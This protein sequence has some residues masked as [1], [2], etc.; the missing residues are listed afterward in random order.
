M[1]VTTVFNSSNCERVGSASMSK[2]NFKT[3][4]VVQNSSH[5]HTTDCRS[6]LHWHSDEPN[7]CRSSLINTSFFPYQNQVT[8]A[9]NICYAFHPDQA[10]PKDVQIQ[11]ILNPH[12][13]EKEKLELN[14]GRFITEIQLTFQM[15]INSGASKFQLLIC[16]PI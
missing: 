10:Y 14:N 12:R 13:S 16:E 11:N 15:G 4:E 2:T 3:R 9:S 7:N 1:V 8:K 6:S 5:D